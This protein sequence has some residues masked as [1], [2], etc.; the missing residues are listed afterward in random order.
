MNVLINMNHN[1]IEILAPAGDLH[2]LKCA[3]D[4]G[5]DAVYLGGKNFG[6]RKNANNFSIDEINEGVS[7]AHLSGA[8]VYVTVNTLLFDDEIED[9]FLFLKNIYN[10][11]VDAIIVQDMAVLCIAKKYFPNLKLH[12]STQMTVHSLDGANELYDE[13]FERVVLSRELSYNEIMNICKNT[14]AEI[15]MF[16]HGAL[17]VC[18]SGQCLMS[19]LIGQRS[20]NR[21]EC[22]QPC[23][24]PFKFV[25]Y[26]GN[27][28]KE[29]KYLFSLKDL[30]LAKKY[31]LLRKLGVK[32]LKIEGRMKNS[33]YVSFVTDMYSG[34]KQGKKLRDDQYLDAEKIFSRSG[35][36]TGY[37]D[38]DKGR[39]MVNISSNNDDIYKNIPKDLIERCSKM[40]DKRL[41]PVY[42]KITAKVGEP[43]RLKMWTDEQTQAEITLDNEICI[44]QNVPMTYDK[45]YSSINKLGDT[46]FYLESLDADFDENAFVPVRDFNQARRFCT[47][48]L[49]NNIKKTKREDVSF[50]FSYKTSKNQ[51]C[52]FELRAKVTTRDQFN[53]CIKVNEIKK[54][55]LEYEEFINHRDYYL[56]HRD[57]LVVCLPVIIRDKFIDKIDLS[58]VESV[59]VSN[60][61]HFK[62]CR[63]KNIYGDEGLNV[64]NSLSCSYYAEKGLKSL[65]LSPEM[66]LRQATYINSR[67]DTE[68]IAYGRLSLMTS[69]NCLI[70]TNYGK[71]VCNDRRFFSVIDRKGKEFP[72]LSRK[73]NC[74]NT[75]YNSAPVYMGDR[76]DEIE[77]AGVS[78]IRLVFTNEDKNTVKEILSM[79]KKRQKP[80]FD[81]TRGHF[82]RGVLDHENN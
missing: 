7:Y 11:G 10:A 6:A 61:G 71:C 41:R 21:G 8:K 50:D 63:G 47:E 4:N 12:A 23:R 54:I 69:E 13:G 17:C 34:L 49:E 81:Y 59:S 82:Y 40:G 66:N 52:P 78:A 1:D 58:D 29:P 74:T 26:N 32:S 70:K 22:A 79:Y 73:F 15:E 51:P 30:C 67:I 2:A 14:K 56:L 36:T 24:L 35:F 37:F 65:V 33:E 31:D 38:D 62:L 72:V 19:S 48:M 20:G 76:L 80:T 9:L 75:V 39:H 3:V 43:L 42:A 16:V 68:V 18:Y 44:A 25:D 28:A 55:F 60:I 27:A 53:E 46:F 77:R 45:I 57:K 5:A 64:T